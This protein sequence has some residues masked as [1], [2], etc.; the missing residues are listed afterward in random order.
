MTTNRFQRFQPLAGVLGG[1]VFAMAAILTFKE[2]SIG[3]GEQKYVR[4]YA[5]NVALELV[6]GIAAGYFCVLMLLFATEVRRALHSGERGSSAHANAAFAGGIT[7]AV[8]VAV[9]GVVGM[10]SAEAADKH[11]SQ[12]AIAVGYL[13]DNLFL[14]F[15]AGLAAFYL[16]TG[17]GA[18][19]TGMLPKWL[20]IVT[21]VL[22]VLCLGGPT[23]IGVFFV[24]PVWLIVTGI[25][26]YRRQAAPASAA[27]ASAQ[28]E[29]S[30]VGAV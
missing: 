30:H 10:A 26:L 23:G 1:L 25:L 11:N 8:G 3:D 18:L 9:L 12:A 15:V 6:A 2:P 24:T 21:I 13:S 20:S 27:N 14:L 5:D 17:L 19:R 16:A 4:W 22:G 29:M 7:F 28:S